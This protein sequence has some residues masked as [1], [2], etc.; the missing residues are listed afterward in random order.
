MKFPKELVLYFIK[1]TQTYFTLC[2]KAAN[3]IFHNGPTA[4]NFG[5]NAFRAREIISD[6]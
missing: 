3:F 5:P 4:S 6:Q 1:T 2:F